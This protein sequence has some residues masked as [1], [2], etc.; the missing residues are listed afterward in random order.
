[1]IS[2]DRWFYAYIF[3]QKIVRVVQIIKVRAF[4]LAD[5]VEVPDKIEI[6]E[7]MVYT[8]RFR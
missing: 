1:M 4:Q 6:K 7:W 5:F 3:E 2:V 8:A